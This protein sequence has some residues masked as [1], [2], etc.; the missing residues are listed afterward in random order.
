MSKGI[1]LAEAAQRL[2]EAGTR[3]SDRYGRGTQGK[4]Q[5]WA[6]GAAGSEANWAAGV[7]DA[8]GKKSF[9]RGVSDAGAGSYEAGVSRKGVLNWPTGMQMAG[10]EYTRKTQ[11]F[12]ALWNQPLPTPRGTRR[13]AANKQRM[14][15]NVDRFEK[16]K[17]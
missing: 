13:S 14:A 11:K 1:T 17:G 8:I 12:A 10:D 6:S 16:A 4:G 15:Q 9:S 5:R 2:T 7:Q 3:L